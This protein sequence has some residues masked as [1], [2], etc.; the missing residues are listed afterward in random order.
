[1]YLNSDA[2]V[3]LWIIA[4][5]VS[6]TCPKCNSE[7]PDNAKF[8][9]Q[10]AAPLVSTEQAVVKSKIPTWLAVVLVLA[11]AFIGIA[12]WNMMQ[13]NDRLRANLRKTASVSAAEH[14]QYQPTTH[15]VPLTNGAATVNA[16]AY[17]WYKFDVPENVSDVLVNG[18]VTASG[19]T[20]NDIVCYIL[21][22]DGFTNFKNGHPTSTYYNSGKVT[23]AKIQVRNLSP[24]TYYIMLDNRF[25]LLT[26][27]AVEIQATLTYV[28]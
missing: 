11:L 22:E 12:V 10:C 5:R 13:E 16:T 8:C 17:T 18:H 26:P 20:G 7:Q 6:M 9:S 24:G 1:L 25:S 4:R 15:S 3:T 19:G 14:P 27:K 21:D 28:Q 23:T 2:D